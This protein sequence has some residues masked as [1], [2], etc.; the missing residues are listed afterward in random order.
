VAVATHAQGFTT[1]AGLIPAFVFHALTSIAGLQLLG[2]A[3]K[4][5]E[6]VEAIAA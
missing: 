3:R 1:L 5:S 2:M 6:P 4:R